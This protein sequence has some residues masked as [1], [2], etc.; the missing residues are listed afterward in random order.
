MIAL[1]RKASLDVHPLVG[2][3]YEQVFAKAIT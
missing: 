3:G 2:N 1:K